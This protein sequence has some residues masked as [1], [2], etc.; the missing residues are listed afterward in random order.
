M[1]LAFKQLNKIG[2]LGTLRNNNPYSLFLLKGKEEWDYIYVERSKWDT[3]FNEKD[4]AVT[5]ERMKTY[6]TRLFSQETE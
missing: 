4:A 5:E 6:I 3:F 1:D 2:M